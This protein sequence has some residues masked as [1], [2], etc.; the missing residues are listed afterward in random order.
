MSQQG[1]KYID[2]FICIFAK[3]G[4]RNRFI[5]QTS[6][7]QSYLMW[8][9]MIRMRDPY[10]RCVYWHHLLLLMNKNSLGYNNSPFVVQTSHWFYMWP[11]YSN[12]NITLMFL[13]RSTLLCV[14]IIVCLL[15]NCIYNILQICNH[16]FTCY[17]SM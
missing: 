8:R 5:R 9:K 14:D 7:Q 4:K 15:Q 16:S 6:L 12:L 10:N 11:T 2:L 13:C 1:S 17:N 3:S